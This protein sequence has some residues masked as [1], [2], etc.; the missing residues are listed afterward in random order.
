M[1]WRENENV[2][3]KKISKFQFFIK[4]FAPIL[5]RPW[6][7]K[8]LGGFMQDLFIHLI[9]GQLLLFLLQKA[10]IEAIFL[11]NTPF[12]FITYLYY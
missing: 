6:P 9:P 7:W 1:E 11:R 2:F 8:F 3:F 5:N 4:F 10:G 12:Q